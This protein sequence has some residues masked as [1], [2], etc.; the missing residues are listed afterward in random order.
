MVLAT[1]KKTNAPDYLWDDIFG[2]SLN[3]RVDLRQ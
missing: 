2:W 1:P 3:H